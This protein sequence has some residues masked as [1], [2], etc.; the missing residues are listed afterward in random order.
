[1]DGV[2]GI[3]TVSDE[4]EARDVDRDVGATLSR[5]RIKWS[6]NSERRDVKRK[7][8]SGSACAVGVLIKKLSK[9]KDSIRN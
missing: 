7:N 3:E 8:V 4:R 5:D 6:R 2:K 9:P 1:M